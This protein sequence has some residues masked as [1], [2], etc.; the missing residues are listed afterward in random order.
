[1][2]LPPLNSEF[3]YAYFFASFQISS[4]FLNISLNISHV[5]NLKSLFV[6]SNVYFY[7]LFFSPHF[8]CSCSWL[9]KLGAKCHMSNIT[10]INFVLYWHYLICF[11][12]VCYPY[13]FVSLLLEIFGILTHNIGI[14]P[15]PIVF[16]YSSL[17]LCIATRL[18]VSIVCSC[19]AA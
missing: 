14:L 13:F 5:T 11:P 8:K 9:F 17:G 7:N 16:F 15:E 1:M 2:L 18:S 3:I 10:D 19:L 6:V 12:L 4:E